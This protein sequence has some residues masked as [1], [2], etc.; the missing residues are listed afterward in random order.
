MIKVLRNKNFNT[1][2][3]IKKNKRKLEE[4]ENLN[5]WKRPDLVKEKEKIFMCFEDAEHCTFEP[6]LMNNKGGVE[7][8]KEELI[9]SRLNNMKWVNDMGENFTIVRGTI[10]KEGILKR[11]KILFADGRYQDT[12][13]LLKKAFDLEA[14]KIFKEKGEYKP[15]DKGQKDDN[16]PKSIFDR[17]RDVNEPTEDFKNT[18]NLQL[19]DEVY[20]MLTAINK[21]K[22]KQK[23]QIKK[24][25]KEIEI[26][27]YNKQKKID[28]KE[29][30]DS[31][32]KSGKFAYYKDKYFN[33]FKTV[34]CPLK[35][36]CPYLIPRW[37]H[38]DKKASEQYGSSCPYAHQVSEL[39]FDQEIREKIKFRKNLLSSLEKGQ[40]PNIKYEWVPTGP[41]VSCI[42]CGMS[43]DDK[44]RV[45]TVIANGGNGSGA[46]KGSCGFCQYNKRNNKEMELNKRATTEKNKKLLDKINYE[47]KPEEIDQDY[48][49]KFGK[50][51]KAIILYGFR[52]YTDCVKIMDDLMESVRVEQAEMDQKFKSLDKKWRKKL[53]INEE[54]NPEILNYNIDQNVLNYFNI[55]TPLATILIYC[56]KMRKGNKLSIYNRHTF[57]NTQIKEFDEVIK[58]TMSKYDTDVH[59]LRKQIDDLS[60]WITK[61][62]KLKTQNK[63]KKKRITKKMEIKYKNHMCDSK[64]TGKSCDKGFRECNKGAHNPNQLNLINPK[65]EKELMV[66]NMKTI[67]EEKKQSKSNV[68]WSY[69]HQGYIQPGPRFNRSILNQY[70]K[71][72]PEVVG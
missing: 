69:A 41:I 20:F 65:K 22:G 25:K 54:I 34:M 52:R 5:L 55:K 72:V 45:H 59:H 50:L 19:C 3:N 61:G 62:K 47:S 39:K 11:A 27:E 37:P 38:S 36:Q 24:L 71:E 28:T 33:F 56:D 23:G 17:K 51:K 31:L 60:L 44:K 30:N 68:P 40:E 43:F 21:Y 63:K 12:I 49:A 13:K 14:I 48:M 35:E 64:M 15:K 7:E 42:G 67:L 46:A 18:K 1:N 58:K 66:N 53:E 8:D 29:I 26:I 57:L 70:G 32:E 4:K 2:F 9:N 16:Q 6:K 10:Y